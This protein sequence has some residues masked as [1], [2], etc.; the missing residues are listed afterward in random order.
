[1]NVNVSNLQLKQMEEMLPVIDAWD[2]LRNQSTKRNCH[3]RVSEERDGLLHRAFSVFLFNSENKLLLQQRS[4]SKITFPNYFTNT[5]CSHPRYLE[6]ELIEENNSGIKLAAQRRLNYE[7][8]IPATDVPLEKLHFLTKIHYYAR[9]DEQWC[10][11]EIDY[12]LLC[13]TDTDLSNVNEDEVQK[14]MYVSQDELKDFLKTKDNTT[15]IT[16]WFQYIADNLLYKWWD[17]LDNVQNMSDNEIHRA[18]SLT[19]EHDD[20]YIFGRHKKHYSKRAR[21]YGVPPNPH[22]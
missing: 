14:T 12:V 3:L 11:H 16:P 19:R 17:N 20:I 18:G 15:L 1:M 9:A 5:C 2:I 6:D 22:K 21:K 4:A 8:G 13:K 7:L 10:E